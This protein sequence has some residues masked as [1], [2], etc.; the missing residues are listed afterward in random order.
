MD[1]RSPI[2]ISHRGAHDT[3]PE[4]SLAAFDR[5]I[6][7]GADAIELDVHGTAD[8]ELLVHHDPALRARGGASPG[9]RPISE[10]SAADIVSF[11][12]ADG[13][14]IPTLAEAL[15]RIGTRAFVYVEIKA[16]NIEQRVLR[17]LRES[18][19]LA[20]VHSFD[21]RIARQVK[22]LMPAM[23]TGV[24]Q[25]ARPLDPI[26]AARA[27]GAEDL[28]QHTDYIDEEL[29]ALAHDAGLSVIAWTA[30]DPGRWMSLIDAGV[31]GICSDLIADLAEFCAAAR[32]RR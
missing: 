2:A 30:N 13:N 25:V 16:R 21:H 31:D 4:N 24:L 27:A 29:V 14:R 12:L 8:G 3:L 9:M 6:D 23:R 1:L 32:A 22:E 18:D 17:T 7:A 5:A 26:A 15:E 28:W 20:A 19:S 10:L 11:P